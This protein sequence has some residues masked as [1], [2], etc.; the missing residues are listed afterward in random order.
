MRPILKLFILACAFSTLACAHKKASDDSDANARGQNASIQNT[1]MRLD[2]AGS[3]GHQIGGLSSI[4]FA[5]DHSQ[6]DVEG[7]RLLAQNVDWLSKHPKMKLEIQGH[8]DEHG[9]SEYNLALGDR[10]ARAA[11]DYMVSLGANAN[12]LTTVSFGKERLL[13]HESSA[14]AD[15]QNRRDNFVPHLATQ[16]GAR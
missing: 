15:Q 4:H 14:Q 10:R 6:L 3:D 5:Y 9:S 7:R 11:R 8:C 13:N 2:D 12:L 16:L 1:D